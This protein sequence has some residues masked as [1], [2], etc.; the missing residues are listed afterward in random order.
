MS[1]FM[2]PYNM[3]TGDKRKTHHCTVLF[4]PLSAGL[5]HELFSIAILHGLRGSSLE[6]IASPDRTA[7][8]DRAICT[9]SFNR[10]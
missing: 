6:L 1:P 5:D 7:C 8:S 3:N 10:F 9:V 4:E 2:V